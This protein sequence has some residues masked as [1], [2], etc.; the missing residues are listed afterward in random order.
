MKRAASL[1]Y[2]PNL[3]PDFLSTTNEV[4]GLLPP[5]LIDFSEYNCTRYERWPPELSPLL[6]IGRPLVEMDPG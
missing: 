5:G 2:E 1:A 3:S 4:A 6:D